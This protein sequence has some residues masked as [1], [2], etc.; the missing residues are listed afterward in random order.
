MGVGFE[1]WGMLNRDCW[2]LVGMEITLLDIRDIT[3]PL[4]VS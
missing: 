3:P 4:S 2:L 1:N